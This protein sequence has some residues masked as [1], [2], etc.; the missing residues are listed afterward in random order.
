MT[1]ICA[2]FDEDLINISEVTSR[3]TKW[4]RFLAYSVDLHL[5]VGQT[6][7]SCLLWTIIWCCGG[8]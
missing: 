6:T 3:K 8:K 7:G 1:L 5:S 2:K 4:S